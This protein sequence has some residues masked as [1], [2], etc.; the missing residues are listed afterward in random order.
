MQINDIKINN[1][2]NHMI[3]QANGLCLKC[4]WTKYLELLYTFHSDTF[5]GWKEYMK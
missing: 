2:I 4:L 5:Q 3:I 1:F